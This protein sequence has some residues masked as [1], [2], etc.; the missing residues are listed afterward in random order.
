MLCIFLCYTLIEEA[1]TGKTMKIIPIDCNYVAPEFATSYLLVHEGRGFFV[2]CNTN[3]AIPILKKA[4]EDA[5]LLAE[6]VDGLLITH[7]HLDHAGGAGLFLKEFPSAVLYAHPRAA[8]HAIDPS[9]LIASATKVYG[10]T[11]MSKIYGTILPCDPSRVKTLNDGDRI[12]WQGLLFDTKHTRGHANHHL[13]M[14]EPVTKTL[15]SGDAFGVSYP[16]INH[17]HGLVIVA[18]TSPTDF[19]G[20]AAIETIAWVQGLMLSGH[21]LQVALTHFGFLKHDQIF[22][23]SLQLIEYL[24]FSM[25]LQKRIKEENLDETKVYEILQTWLIHDHAKHGR[26]LD[27]SDLELLKIDLQVNAQG[28]CFSV[29]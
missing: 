16:V 2:E 14:V 10:E 21:I 24:R 12:E 26:Y 15:F 28:L 11:F 18:S 5:G 17:K 13:C 22:P 9:K 27:A 4:A 3:Y 6:Q 23:A 8:R 29:S 19:D 25:E 20:P 7:V 1:I